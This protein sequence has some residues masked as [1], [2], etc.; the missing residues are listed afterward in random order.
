VG[1]TTGQ[2]SAPLIML[3]YS[4]DGGRTFPARCQREVSVRIGRY[5][6]RVV[7]QSLGSSR[8]GRV[9]RAAV[10]DP[11]KVVI[12]DTQAEVEGGSWA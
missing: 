9:Y 3:E 11:V 2:G 5:E 10:S 6:D 8:V 4:N 1:L 12:R 7:W